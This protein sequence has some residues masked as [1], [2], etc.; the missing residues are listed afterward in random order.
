MFKLFFG[1]T[2]SCLLIFSAIAVVLF[3]ICLMILIKKAMKDKSNKIDFDD[4]NVLAVVLRGLL[5]LLIF[6]AMFSL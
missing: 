1:E 3:A 2:S 6:T 5:M 4:S